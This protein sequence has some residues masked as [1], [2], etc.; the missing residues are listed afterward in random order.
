[1]K[2]KGT[3]KMEIIQF[4]DYQPPPS[5]DVKVES[6][7]EL[8]PLPFFDAGRSEG[9]STW[10]VTPTGN[11][12]ADCE[13][14]RVFA[15]EFLKSCDKT[16]GWASLMPSITADMIRAGTTGSFAN[17]YPRVN[18]IVI[19]FMRVIGSALVHSRVLDQ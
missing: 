8:Y 7:F 16:C 6:Q 17:G 13:T 14:G 1:L 2:N 5:K 3:P 10:N 12:S 4:S 11:Y 9:P 19:G 15:I 18:G